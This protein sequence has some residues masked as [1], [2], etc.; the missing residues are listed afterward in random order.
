M[1]GSTASTYRPTGTARRSVSEWLPTASPK[2]TVAA[3]SQRS[4]RGSV[5]DHDRPSPR[6]RSSQPTSSRSRIA[7]SARWRTCGSA[8]VPIDQAIGVRASAEAGGDPDGERAGQRPDQ[9]DRHGGG[10]PE[11]DRREQVHAERVV[12][13]RLEDDRGEPAQEDVGR[14]ARRVGRAQDGPDRLE[15]P[16]VPERDAGQ[17]RRRA[18][19][20]ATTPTARAGARCEGPVRRP[21]A[22]L[23]STFHA[24]AGAVPGDWP[25]IRW[26]RAR[27]SSAVAVDRD[28]GSRRRGPDRPRAR[29]RPSAHHRIPAPRVRTHN[30]LGA[31]RFWAG[32]LAAHGPLG[33]YDR[34]F[35]HDY[36]PGYMYVLW[37]VGIV[38][39]ALGGVSVELIK[40]PPI[41]ADL[42]IGY[43]AWSMIRE[44]GGRER[45]AL[46]AAFVAV[47]NPISWFDSVVWG[48]VDSFGV[49]FM[50]LGLREL[51]RDRP[52]R[53][54][55]WTVVAAI[56]K[57]QLGILVPLVA[58]VTI[59]R[60]APRPKGGFGDEA[61]TGRPIRIVTTGLVG[62]GTAVLAGAAVRA[63]AGRALPAAPDRGRHLPLPHGQ[64]LQPV[65]ARDRR[66]RLQPRQQRPVGVRPPARRRPVRVRRRPSSAPSRRSSS[67]RRCC[68]SGSRRCWWWPGDGPTG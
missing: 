68:S 61:A 35:L 31:F 47:V 43:L 23:R 59:R 39:Q 28:A 25:R 20:N 64:R 42:A 26:V 41:I 60:G 6:T 50:L 4:A 62:L 17:Q 49:V 10:D 37:L 2:T 21:C 48:Q 8:C 9:V 38:G 13:E 14:E 34:D 30:D 63:D 56:I 15:L 46:A 24:R 3:T 11:A 7:T 5:A 27:H 45:I 16:G 58:I 53:A 54:A 51:W 12:A 55:V 57:P 18:R 1:P 36:T 44:L 52:E 22:T 33:F 19:A 65:G 67:G 66:H 40:V 29:A 32:E